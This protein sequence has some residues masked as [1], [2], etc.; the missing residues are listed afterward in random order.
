MLFSSQAKQAIADTFY[1]KTVSICREETSLDAEGGV[2]RGEL[3]V[4]S[5]FRGNVRFNNLGI[6]QRDLGLDK[7]INIAI[8]CPTDTAVAVGD[9][10]QYQDVIYIVTAVIPSDSHLTITG[11]N[12]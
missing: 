8:T 4:E 10:L 6:I 12:R 11:V 3:S 7:E 5:S 1:D 2:R 9:L